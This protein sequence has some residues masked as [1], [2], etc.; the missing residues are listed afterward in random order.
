[1]DTS[2]NAAMIQ[3]WTAFIAILILKALKAQSK[4]SWLL[5]NLVVFI[6]LN[7]FVKIDLQNG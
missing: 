3:I 5:S 2:K 1:M 7:I 6:Q 4:F